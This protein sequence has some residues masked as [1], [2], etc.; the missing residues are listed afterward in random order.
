[1]QPYRLY[2]LRP[3]DHIAA[4]REQMCPSD[5]DALAWAATQA[6]GRAMEL[7]CLARRVKYFPV[8]GQTAPT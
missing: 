6:D 8:P 4:V 7:W 5:E 3:G 1:M 2:F